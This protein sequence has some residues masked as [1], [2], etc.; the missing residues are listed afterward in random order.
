[1]AVSICV[2]YFGGRWICRAKK[3]GNKAKVITIAHVAVILGFLLV[4]KYADF[5]IRTVSGLTGTELSLLK[6]TLPIGISFYTFQIISYLIDVYRGEA[7]AERNFID[8][9]AYVTMF[10]QLIAGPIVRFRTIQQELHAR[11]LSVDNISGGISRFVCGLAKKVLIAD[12][13]G[14]LVIHLD[15]ISAKDV[16]TYWVIAFAYAFQIYY[17]FSGY[18][19]MA[20]GLGK[21]LGFSFPENFN[22]PYMAKNITDFWRRW[23]MSLGS[24]FRDYV[25]IPLGGSRVKYTRWI[26]NVLV[27]WFLSGLWHGASWNF[28]IWGLYF[29]VLLMLEKLTILKKCSSH[30][31]TIILV[32]ISFVIFRLEDMGQVRSCLMGM[33]GIGAA[34]SVDKLGIYQ[35]KSYGFI[36]IVAAFGLT[37]IVKKFLNRLDESDRGRKVKAIA[38]PVVNLVLL[39]LVTAFLIQSSVH[40]FLYFRFQKCRRR[41]DE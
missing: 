41:A 13:L 23:H 27:V 12:V 25:Y 19:D 29:G 24:W 26:W 2:G 15:E 34:A 16:L 18:C 37:P 17:D 21:M 30:L 1:M 6:W 10:P 8:F 22:Y 38:T 9:A 14:E 11:R 7:L 39:I 5:F 33:F 31:Y 20:I 35:M 40:P 36:L 28:V 32:V 4:F 3:T